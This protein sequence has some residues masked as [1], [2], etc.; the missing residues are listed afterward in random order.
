MNIENWKQELYKFLRNYRATPHP[1][2]G[3][4]PSNLIFQGRQFRCRLP[5]T[6]KSY[7]DTDI[8]MKD[9][10]A[11]TK[12]KM[13]ADQCLNVSRSSIAVGD[14]VL[15]RQ[16]KLNKFTTP[17]SDI[18]YYVI[19]KKGSMLTARSKNGKIITRNISFFKQ[20]KY[21]MDDDYIVEE[22]NL[23]PDEAAD[24]SNPISDRNAVRRFL[25]ENDVDLLS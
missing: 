5:E 24:V 20:L 7:A 16:K 22:E 6:N 10:D 11:K 25:F 4:S 17:F 18:P 21:D 23:I 8:R 1:S 19:R 14:K 13:Y 2:T 12:M 3:V 15:V 9:A